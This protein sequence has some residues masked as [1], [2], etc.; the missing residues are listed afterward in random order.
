[1]YIIKKIYN[2]YIWKKKKNNMC[3][4]FYNQS[5]RKK[6]CWGYF[7]GYNRSINI[8]DDDDWHRAMIAPRGTTTAYNTMTIAKKKKSSYTFVYT[9]VLVIL[10]KNVILDIEIVRT[11]VRQNGKKIWN[12]SKLAAFS[13]F[14]L[15]FMVTMSVTRR[16][17]IDRVKSANTFWHSECHVYCDNHKYK[18]TVKQKK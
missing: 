17:E 12:D 15:F 3:S 7:E 10:W 16:I 9:K 1:M 6:K 11:R 8:N 18:K 13:Y 5:K 2:K 4:V 14:I